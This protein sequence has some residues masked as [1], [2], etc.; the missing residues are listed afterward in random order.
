M[1]GERIAPRAQTVAIFA[2]RGD[3]LTNYDDTASPAT[4]TVDGECSAELGAAR[5]RALGTG[6]WPAG[7]GRVVAAWFRKPG[8]AE[9]PSPIC[10]QPLRPSPSA[11]PI[12]FLLKRL[13]SNQNPSLHRR[14]PSVALRS[15]FLRPV[16]FSNC[17]SLRL[18][19]CSLS[20]TSSSSSPIVFRFLSRS[21]ALR[22]TLPNFSDQRNC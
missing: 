9:L 17:L 21:T 8:P 14:R 1:A 3:E 13:A 12:C 22:H 6:C 19:P 11:S 10:F 7:C 15:F 16:G 18:L 20:A 5:R 2:S 4:A